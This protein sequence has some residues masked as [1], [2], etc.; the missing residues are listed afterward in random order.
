MPQS[1]MPTVGANVPRTD[2][3][4]S[5]WLGSSGSQLPLPNLE[6]EEEW[7]TV[8]SLQGPN[9]EGHRGGEKIASRGSFKIIDEKYAFLPYDRLYADVV[10]Q[11]R[12]SCQ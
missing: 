12:S 4:H 11:L 5:Q 1:D 3:H 9:L 7:V 2:P 6:G 10:F 8:E